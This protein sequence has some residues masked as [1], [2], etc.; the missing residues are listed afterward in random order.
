MT[1]DERLALL[2]EFV[3]VLKSVDEG[4]FVLF[5]EDHELREAADEAQLLLKKLVKEEE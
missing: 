1:R 3:E 4:Q 2:R 5:S